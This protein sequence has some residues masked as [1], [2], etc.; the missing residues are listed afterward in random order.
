MA[1]RLVPATQA[2]TFIHRDY[3]PGNTL[4]LRDRFGG[5]VDWTSASWGPPWVDVGHMRWNLATLF[6]VPVANRFLQACGRL[7]IAPGYSPEFDIRST[8]DVL[9]ELRAAG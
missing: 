4:W 6:G 3:H 2:P 9:P 8:L 1:R 5:A 7:N